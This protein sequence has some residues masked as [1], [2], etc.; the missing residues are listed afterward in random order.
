MGPAITLLYLAAAIVGQMAD[1]PA[2]RFAEVDCAKID[3]SIAKEPRYVAEPRYALFVLD[4]AGEFR[5]WAVLDKSDVKSPRYDVVY[6]DKD[7]DGDLAEPG[8]RF[9][10]K[11]DKEAK[12][13]IIVV[14]DLAVPGTKLVHTGLR[15]MTTESHGY[16]GTFFM[17]KWGGQQDVSGGY[18]SG[19]TDLTTYAQSPEAAPVLRPTPLGLL[20]IAF[21]EPDATLKFGRPTEIQVGIGK[22]GSTP[23]AFCA[24]S[25][26]FLVP[27][28]DVIVAT[29][30]ARARDGKPLRGQTEF[31]KHC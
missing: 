27:G 8:E 5:A 26:H 20:T 14:G 6:F 1:R 9:V 29:L 17:M 2:E 16:K 19:S 3:R 4:P 31:K 15:F 18:T 22:E 13:L 10:G 25:E 30:I 23:D 24:S 12:N 7:G 28:K 21:W 11:Y